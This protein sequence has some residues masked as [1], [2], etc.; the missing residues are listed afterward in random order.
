[1]L[2]RKQ[3]QISAPSFFSF[4]PTDDI[5]LVMRYVAAQQLPME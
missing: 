4:E 2:T 5:D 3:T 1:M